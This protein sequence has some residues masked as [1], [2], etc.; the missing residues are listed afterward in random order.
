M[1]DTEVFREVDE[2]Y[3]RDRM[4]AFWRRHG[5]LVMVFVG[6][7]LAAAAGLQYLHQRN[8]AEQAAQTTTLDQLINLATP[9]NELRAAD[10]LAA[11]AA[12]ADKGHAILARLTEASLRQRMGNLGGAS[13]L[14]H[15]IA[16]DGSVEQNMRDLAIV[17]LG[18]IAVDQPNPEP[19]IPRLAPIA[20]K[21]SPWRYS[22]KEAM[23]LLTAR[24]G[25]KASAATQFSEIAQDP[26]APPDLAQRA[27]D[28][29]DFYRR[30]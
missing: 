26:G 2:D 20:S 24:A 8:Q 28:L 22:A 15:A 29:A 17:R 25:Q 5:W 3:R 4:I 13:A 19:L 30:N 11:F 18:Y 14:Y 6:L 10:A 12:K 1:S 16:D 7:S 27:R 23:A 21:D 9:G